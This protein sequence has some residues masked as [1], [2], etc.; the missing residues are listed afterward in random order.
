MWFSCPIVQIGVYNSRPDE[1]PVDF[2][3]R[4]RDYA[5]SATYP[6]H[7]QVASKVYNE[8]LQGVDANN[9]SFQERMISELLEVREFTYGEVNF[10]NFLPMLDF[11]RPKSGEVF[12]DLGCGSG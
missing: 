7:V 3:I 11:V 6:P 5:P 10:A 4:M 2:T 12:Y 1:G 8:A 9:T